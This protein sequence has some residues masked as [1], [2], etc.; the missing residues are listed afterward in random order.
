M[1]QLQKRL[2]KWRQRFVNNGFKNPFCFV[3]FLFVCLFVWGSKKLKISCSLNHTILFK[4]HYSRWYKHFVRNVWRD[5]R[6]LMSALPTVAGNSFNGKFTAK[7]DFSIGYFIL[8]LLMLTMEVWSRSIHYLVSILTTCWW[9]LNKIVYLY[10]WFYMWNFELCDKKMVNHFWQ[11]VLE[12]VP[13]TET[14][15]WCKTINLK[16]IIFQCSKNHGSPTR[17]TRLKVAPNMANPIS[18]NE[19]RP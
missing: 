12:D 4:F 17:V 3:L 13:V 18:L 14:I 16:T 5:F 10:M 9:N 2:P 8:P 11:S 6:L 15:V 19:K 7:I 1:F